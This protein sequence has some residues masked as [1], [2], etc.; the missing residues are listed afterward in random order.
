MN[1]KL[2]ISTT[3]DLWDAILQQNLPEQYLSLMNFNWAPD[4]SWDALTPYAR[5]A[6]LVADRPEII[7][8]LIEDRNWRV[9]LFGVAIAVLAD[10]KTLLDSMINRI[11]DSWVAP[12]I[13][14]GT[15]L[16]IW[17]V[18]D[19][20]R[21]VHVEKLL[22]IATASAAGQDMKSVMSA[23]AVLRTCFKQE[24]KSYGEDADFYRKW[25][26]GGAWYDLAKTHYE[27]W[28]VVLP[29]LSKYVE[30]RK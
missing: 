13:A 26:V 5:I 4:T 20:E 8:P 12:Q 6:A 17:D 1:E 19:D 11:A 15:A 10:A 25:T 30:L 7:R 16:L 21:K 22:K 2:I 18:E 3:H 24:I 28:R 27:R 9:N 14:A 29:Y 23:Y